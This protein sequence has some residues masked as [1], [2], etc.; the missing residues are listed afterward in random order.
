[1]TGLPPAYST[2]TTQKPGCPFANFTGGDLQPNIADCYSNWDSVQDI[3]QCC[4]YYCGNSVIQIN[5]TST[6]VCVDDPATEWQRTG[7]K[8]A[9]EPMVAPQCRDAIVEF[10]E[11]EMIKFTIPSCFFAALLL[12]LVVSAF[13]MRCSIQM[14]ND[15]VTLR[16]ELPSIRELIPWEKEKSTSSGDAY[17]DD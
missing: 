10:F 4:G 13:V 17:R 6:P 9:A 15:R 1:M 5:G 11:K 12:V 14:D 3:L 8:C 16:M 2:V 7:T